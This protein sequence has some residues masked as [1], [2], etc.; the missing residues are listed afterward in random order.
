VLLKI[1]R[2]LRARSAR[3]FADLRRI[4]A[5]NGRKFP[6]VNAH[7]EFVWQ[8]GEPPIASILLGMRGVL[9]NVIA[10]IERPSAD[11][12]ADVHRVRLGIKRLRALLRLLRAG[13][14]EA[15]YRRENRR[16]K[17]ISQTLAAHRDLQVC[18][19][20][21]DWLAARAHT[22]HREMF[23]MLSVRHFRAVQ[24]ES[25]REAALRKVARE[26]Q[27]VKWTMNLSPMADQLELVSKALRKTC[28]T[29]RK[30]MKAA[31]KRQSAVAFHQW[32]IRVKTLEYQ[33]EWL[34]PRRRGR[35]ERLLKRLEKL[36]E[37]L[38]KA[39]DLV[40]LEE[41]I[42]RRISSADRQ[43][44]RALRS[45]KKR[46]QTLQGSSLRVGA[47]IF[48]KHSALFHCITKW[49]KP[50]ARDHRAA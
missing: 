40:I 45:M 8:P 41:E 34:H 5:E 46:R 42:E 17:A 3:K 35:E 14:S 50:R 44:Q 26:L 39:H 30:R 15:A 13:M 49:A 24:T 7:P 29:A 21:L 19:Q 10:C 23:R 47:K 43:T 20:T 12:A 9:T 31:R 28:R 38:G 33:L 16:L 2:F 11:R 18:R 37:R 48:A 4:F 6:P 36:Q 1:P 32:R 27:R 25:Q 22:R